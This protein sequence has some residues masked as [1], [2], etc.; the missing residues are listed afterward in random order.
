MRYAERGTIEELQ[1]RREQVINYFE[2]VALPN[3][4]LLQKAIDR[5]KGQMADDSARL[6]VLDWPG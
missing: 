5:L 3:D 6:K 2:K 1:R 4:Q